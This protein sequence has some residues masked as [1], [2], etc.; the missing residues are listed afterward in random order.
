MSVQ[1]APDTFGQ[2]EQT[3]NENNKADDALDK[4]T[5][6]ADVLTTTIKS[7]V[8]FT[9][10]FSSAKPNPPPERVTSSPFDQEPFE[11]SQTSIDD[12]SDFSKVQNFET[13]TSVISSAPSGS[14]RVDQFTKSPVSV[15]EK[16]GTESEAVSTQDENND[17]P[18][19]SDNEQEAQTDATSQRSTTDFRGTRPETTTTTPNKD[20]ADR[21]PVEEITFPLEP[22][23]SEPS[24]PTTEKPVTG[25]ESDLVTIA[26][27][28]V[29]DDKQTGVAAPS[30]DQTPKD[31]NLATLTPSIVDKETSSN[32]VTTISSRD[33]ASDGHTET[34]STV[35]GEASQSEDENAQS[36]A[37]TTETPPITQDEILAVQPE[38]N[39][40]PEN[41]ETTATE[42][43]AAAVTDAINQSAVTSRPGFVPV[44]PESSTEDPSLV[45]TTVHLKND[46]EVSSTEASN[47]DSV[48][49][50][51]ET[52]T[53]SKVLT[54]ISSSSLSTVTSDTT[55][56]IAIKETDLAAE[57]KTDEDTAAGEDQRAAGAQGATGST[58][59][60]DID[61][62]EDKKVA[63][64]EAGPMEE[65]K[66]GSIDLDKT[67]EEVP[68]Q[69]D[70]DQ[71]KTEDTS[72]KTKVAEGTSSENDSTGTALEKPDN[73]ANVN[74]DSIPE[75]VSETTTLA[76]EVKAGVKN[77]TT[78]KNEQSKTDLATSERP[79][80]QP[81]LVSSTSEI[82]SE[83]PGLVSSTS[84]GPLDQPGLVLSTPERTSEQ[85]GL[86][87]SEPER[88]VGQF[89]PTS[90]RTESPSNELGLAS[91]TTERSSDQ[92]GSGSD[93]T[94]FTFDNVEF[95]NVV[96]TSTTHPV[97]SIIDFLTTFETPHVS[98]TSSTTIDVSFYNSTAKTS[99]RLALCLDGVHCKEDSP[100]C[101]VIHKECNEGFNV[102]QLPF[103]VKKKLSECT[104]DDILCHLEG[105]ESMSNC[106]ATYEKCANIVIPEAFIH[107]V[108]L[109]ENPP[110]EVATVPEPQA[111]DDSDDDDLNPFFTLLALSKLNGGLKAKESAFLQ[112][113]TASILDAVS[114]TVGGIEI[115][116][117]NSSEELNEWLKQK[118]T[119]PIF[120][121][122]TIIIPDE[123]DNSS[124]PA[125]PETIDF[126]LTN[127]SII[128][129][130]NSLVIGNTNARDAQILAKKIVNSLSG[131]VHI[132]SLSECGDEE[133]DYAGIAAGNGTDLADFE[134]LSESEN[135]E[136]STGVIGLNGIPKTTTFAEVQGPILIN[137]FWHDQINCR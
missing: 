30:T 118:D 42:A 66:V 134:D 78:N 117:L 35:K 34:G 67:G 59:E 33:E 123:G 31:D 122:L 86:V 79:L 4:K 6:L 49:G 1:Q 131:K 54:E 95:D 47:L 105:K 62:S 137:S 84:E 83:Q 10:S 64:T 50:T 110:T 89:D 133:E 27:T 99:F 60:K 58:E 129:D 85:P 96:T 108:S 55:S 28:T 77:Q 75:T 82:T 5:G 17:Q 19:K 11:V 43:A 76:A 103:A 88:P 7:I 65:K 12:E 15:P 24:E 119:L 51:K 26:S 124:A 87:S 18:V 36:A 98:S 38:V 71:S 70:E 102:G 32:G 130:P 81:G 2:A 127:S 112:N 14:V 80:D 116:K 93:S 16:I 97:T 126:D 63:S 45:E 91:S 56:S 69:T 74:D 8:D 113:V 57:G 44:Q 107:T 41:A 21:A 132:C 104:V 68:D 53:A 48:T 109:T 92:S 115:L 25:D 20:S 72:S 22:V 46:G 90:Q 94:P 135:P 3:E 61:L 120:H 40:Q 100:R 111:D 23:S 136:E 125:Q 73:L 106:K 39:E 101:A 114:T 128:F 29:G 9:Q 121:D 13:T 37:K 52:T